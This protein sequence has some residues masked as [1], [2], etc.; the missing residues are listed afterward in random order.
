[1][2]P[3]EEHAERGDRAALMVDGAGRG[4]VTAAELKRFARERLKVPGAI[5]FVAALPRNE[6]VK[7]RQSQLEHLLRE[8]AGV[9]HAPGVTGVTG[10]TGQHGAAE[11]LLAGAD[12]ASSSRTPRGTSVRV[13]SPA[14]SLVAIGSNPGMAAQPKFSR[15]SA[16]CSP[17]MSYSADTIELVNKI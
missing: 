13:D 14:L 6:I 11:K 3:L 5:G 8:S 16:W 12:P 17:K 2:G 9:R 7:V 1:V 15:Y 10:V 4:P